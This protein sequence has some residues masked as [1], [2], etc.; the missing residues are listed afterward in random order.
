MTLVDNLICFWGIIEII[1]VKKGGRTDSVENQ[2]I[3]YFR[4]RDKI[5]T[6][7]E[8]LY[9]TGTVAAVT[10]DEQLNLLD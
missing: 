3:F 6:R 7:Q 9:R 1:S 8:F 10:G 4:I 2:F 5:W